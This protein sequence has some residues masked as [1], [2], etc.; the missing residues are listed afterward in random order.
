M[1]AGE[2]EN[3]VRSAATTLGTSAGLQDWNVRLTEFASTKRY[4][5]S[6]GSR[7][8]KGAVYR[9]LEIS[10]TTQA[11]DG[12]RLCGFL[13]YV[14]RDNEAP[15]SDDRLMQDVRKLAADL[16][17]AAA[18]PAIDEYSGPVLF[19]D[20][21]SAQLISQLFAHEL[22]PARQAMTS[23][24]WF[25]RYLTTGKIAGRLNRRVFPEFVTIRDD[26]TLADWEGHALLGYQTVDDE[27]VRAEAITLV[28]KGRLVG[29]PS[30]RQPT[31]KI[32]QSNGH[33]RTLPNQWTVPC[34][35]SLFVETSEPMPMK[36]L[37]EELR[38]IAKESGNDYGLIV[39]LLEDPMVSREYAWMRKDM[40]KPEP[41]T[42]PVLM[43]KVDANSSRIEPVRGLIFDE[44][45]FRSLRDISAMGEEEQLYS[46]FQP[47]MIAE[48]R[49]PMSIVTP[50][51]LVE[52]M[53][54]KSNP[55]HEPK[56]F[57]SN[58]YYEE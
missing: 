29:L 5:N 23:E 6:E 19:T 28:N 17:A 32:R 47:S 12:Q 38:E 44:T 46:V 55:V 48:L 7:Y 31:K 3:T 22:T 39:T 51:I 11:S 41:L 24:E 49:Y 40:D 18:A 20:Y 33:A 42:A 26:P 14:T 56:P 21:A 57:G 1:N 53:E 4:L 16:T 8:L 10:A 34:I 9:Q 52:E 43:Y 15:P 35:S 25:Q 36:Q 27:G 13:S 50:A 37:V 58:P 54:L 30:N 45:S 2:W